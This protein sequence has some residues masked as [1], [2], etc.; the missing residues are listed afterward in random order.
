MP[1]FNKILIANR[2]EIAVRVIRAA[3]ELGIKTVAIYSEAD[4]ESLHVSL[5][6]EA[7][8]IGPPEPLESYLN[9]DKIIE[10][11]IRSGAD[12]IH[13][14]YG[15]LAENASFVKEVKKVGLVFIGPDPE[16][17]K[18]MG[19]KL[20]ARKTA[21]KVHAPVVPGT[22]NPISNLN[23]L[24]KVADEIGYPLLIKPAGG[25][26]G[27]GMKIVWN[28]EEL[29]SLFEISKSEALAAFGS[30]EVY[31][32]KYLKRPRHIEFQI[33]ADNYGNYVYFYERECSIQ[34]R[35]QKLIEESPS[36][37]LNDDLRREMGEFAIKIASKAK[38]N[39]LGTVEFLFT[40]D[41]YYFLEMNTR[42]QVEH[43]V[44]EMISGVDLVK[45]Q[46]LIAGDKKLDIAQEEIKARGWAI[47]A[48]INAEN[49]YDNFTPS[50][51]KIRH[52]RE[53]GGPGVRVD[54]GVYSGYEVPKYYDPLIAKLIVWGESRREAI[55]RM[56]R[57]L[58]EFTITGIETT[59]PLH[60]EIF[61]DPDF[62]SGNIHTRY[63]EDKLDRFVEKLNKELLKKLAVASIVYPRIS[64]SR[65]P[66]SADR[67]H[68]KVKMSD[69][70]RYG[71]YR[72]IL[73][74]YK[75]S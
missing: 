72:L 24:E 75:I 47:E 33:A 64:S 23:E 28:K 18:A 19:D 9:I 46:I 12:A 17:M 68:L 36:V 63:L 3:R 60:K 56:K 52:Y 69:W 71:L 57:A 74:K 10:V 30:T 6:D 27:I 5:A 55:S 42:L 35:Y 29:E 62:Q 49:V 73:N 44:T 21:L 39:N 31:V 11:A 43:G 40:R 25:G 26:G 61:S 45:L 59:I 1:V 34:R 37:A 13:P 8:L 7:Y 38:Y 22:F 53:P 58:S 41:G 50:P 48:R 2:G 4:R 70:K 54:S 32:E 66:I 20:E 65:S 15:F 14:G 51:G 16:P 67:R